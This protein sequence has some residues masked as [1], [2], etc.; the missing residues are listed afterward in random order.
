MA[1]VRK[2]ALIK[3]AACMNLIALIVR[4]EP[5]VHRK[6]MITNTMIFS[7]STSQPGS[8]NSSRAW[9]SGHGVRE[10]TGDQYDL[11]VTHTWRPS[12][13]VRLIAILVLLPAGGLCFYVM[14][15][16][17]GLDALTVYRLLQLL[18]LGCGYTLWAIALIRRS[19][20]L[21]D[22]E[23]IVQNLFRR[24]RLPLGEVIEA[25]ASDQGLRLSATND[26]AI[27]PSAAGP[28]IGF[29]ARR[30]RRND[31]IAK[32]INDRVARHRRLHPAV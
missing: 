6:D 16:Y 23:V 1:N 10:A 30:R 31:E 14:Y 3:L 19:L 5:G 15:G 9:A 26:R 29:R 28:S 2:V 22:A 21:T 25:T 27:S 24:Y 17:V 11:A 20:T 18:L 4:V 32:I 7:V 13:P 8:G 12:L